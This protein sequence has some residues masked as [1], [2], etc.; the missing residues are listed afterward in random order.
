[1]ALDDDSGMTSAD[2]MEFGACAILANNQLSDCRLD[3]ISLLHKAA[4]FRAPTGRE[5]GMA[6]TVHFTMFLLLLQHDETPECAPGGSYG[7][8]IMFAR[9]TTGLQPFNRKFS[10]CSLRSISAVL[11]AI[12]NGLYDKENCFLSHQESFCG[13]NVREENEDCDC[14]YHEKNCRDLCCYARKNSQ[15]AAGCTLRPNAQCSTASRQPRQECQHELQISTF[16]PL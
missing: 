8:Y 6:A 16:E 13:N 2:D 3:G 10:P 4:P 7:N 5:T 1:M 12:I 15:R 11:Y 9:A 14:G